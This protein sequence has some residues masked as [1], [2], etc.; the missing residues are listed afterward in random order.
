MI[1]E[2]GGNSNAE[3]AWTREKRGNG[4]LQIVDLLC[5]EQRSSWMPRM[6]KGRE[7]D[8]GNGANG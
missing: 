8:S 7:C 4:C 1:W 3:V 6:E 5:V 2:G